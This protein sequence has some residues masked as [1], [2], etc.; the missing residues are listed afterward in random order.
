MFKPYQMMCVFS[1]R[2]LSPV[3]LRNLFAGNWL[4]WRL[5]HFA[6]KLLTVRFPC[7]DVARSGD[8]KPHCYACAP[9]KVT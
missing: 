5:P 2:P 8:I 7:D 6:V 9:L 3:N 4:E 1:R